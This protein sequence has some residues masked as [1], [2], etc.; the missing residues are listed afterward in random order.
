VTLAELSVEERQTLEQF[1]D[2][3]EVCIRDVVHDYTNCPAD[4][5]DSIEELRARVLQRLLAQETL[6]PDLRRRE[7]FLNIAVRR[8][9]EFLADIW[10]CPDCGAVLKRESAIQ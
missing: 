10:K 1:I 7:K 3:V 6:H 8:Q 4:S 9:T 5:I 2:L